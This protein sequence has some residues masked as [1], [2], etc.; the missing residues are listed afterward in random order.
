M[1]VAETTPRVV[2]WSA[3]GE[4][5]WSEV[6]WSNL[7]ES[8]ADDVIAE[9]IAHFESLG[10]RFAWRVHDSDRPHDLAARLES[11][12]FHLLGSAEL[13]VARVA[14]MSLDVRVPEGVSLVPAN[15]P[16][17][18][19]RLI[20][21]HE[22]VFQHDHSRLR[23]TLLERLATSPEQNEL[24]VAL[25]DG[26]PVSSARVEFFPGREFAS[27]WGGSTLPEWRGRGL[28]RA[29]VAYRA[30]AA[31]ERGYPYLSVTASSKSRPILE[32]LAFKPLGS[33]LTYEW[34]APRTI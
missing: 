17:G 20:E 8:T 31:A 7:D 11:A 23:R 26:L 15:D 30:R 32:Q 14:T 21:V 24:V 12:G 18:V 34:E 13:M 5:G 29:L 16:L 3:D 1:S 28:F 27:L 4:R 22:K 10:Q 25:A 6:T 19:D 9:Q 2:R 33:I